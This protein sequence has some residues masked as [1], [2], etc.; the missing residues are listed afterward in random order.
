MFLFLKQPAKPRILVFYSVQLYGSW[1]QMLF[2]VFPS[3]NCFR[4]QSEFT[5][6]AALTKKK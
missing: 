5:G 4:Q 3:V 2:T 1:C 6:F